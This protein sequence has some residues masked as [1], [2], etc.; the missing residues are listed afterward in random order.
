MCISLSISSIPNS[1]FGVVSIFFKNSLMLSFRHW[2]VT[3]D[4]ISS[5]GSRLRSEVPFL[6]MSFGYWMLCGFW[7]PRE[8]LDGER[9]LCLAH[10]ALDLLTPRLIWGGEDET[11]ET[12]RK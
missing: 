5:Q 10:H 12:E 7:K 1:E 11:Y 9:Y 6:S 2:S 3:K 8:R 4:V